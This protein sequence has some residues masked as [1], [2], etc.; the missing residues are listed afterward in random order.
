M[1]GYQGWFACPDDGSPLGAWEHWFQRGEPVDTSTQRVDMWPD[2][3]SSAP[4]SAV[5]TPLTLPAGRA[6]AAL[7]GGSTRER[8][9][10]LPLDARVRPGRRVPAAIHV[11]P[12]T[13]RPCSDTGPRVARNGHAAA[14][15]NVRV[16]AIMY[17]VAGYPRE[18]R[19]RR[20][21]ARLGASRGHAARHRESAL[22]HH[23]GR[24]LLA[25]WGFGFTDRSPTPRTGGG[26]D[27]ILQEQ[28]GSPLSR[29][30]ARRRPA[31]WRTLT[32]DSQTDPAWARVYRSLDIVSPWTVGRFRDAQGDRSVLRRRSRG[33]I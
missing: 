7:L 27:R 10:A 17:D 19:C 2:V 18:T 11:V 29:D 28:S 1:F 23:R 33:R 9:A 20:H 15:S 22:L 12:A 3:P 25:I 16:F 26:A 13:S 4:T 21:E 5:T 14:D 30:V 32:R 24:P 31:R 8:R 6:G